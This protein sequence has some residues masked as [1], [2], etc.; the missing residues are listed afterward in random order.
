MAYVPHTPEDVRAM[1]E[2]VG[3]G[4]VDDLFAH[5]PAGVRLDRPLNLP[6]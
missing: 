2:A 5:L 4:S 3:A 6:D 1:L